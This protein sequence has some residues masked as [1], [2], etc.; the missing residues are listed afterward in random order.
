MKKKSDS[1]RAARAN[2][3]FSLI[4]VSIALVMFGIAT[5]YF[6]KFGSNATIEIPEIDAKL[7]IRPHSP[8]KGPESAR[9]TIVEFLD[10]ECE[11]C[12]E[13][14][15]V[16]KR[17]ESEYGE[18]IR[19]VRR[20]LP[21]HGNSRLAA[22]ALEEA[23]E[24]GKYEEALDVLFENQPTWGSHHDPRPELI[25]GYLAGIGVKKASLSRESLLQKHG[26][27]IDLDEKDGQALGIRKTPT[28]FVNGRMLHSIGY[29]PLKQ[30]IDRGLRAN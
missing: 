4:V 13:L 1:E 9:V 16:L 26:W 28:F 12:R 11:S 30:A 18:Q 23:R 7:L 21:F 10:P 22:S 14:H 6:Q 20:Y 27:K 15:G 3:I 17:I 5:I 25:A 19:I 29:D 8:V 2:R 24:Q